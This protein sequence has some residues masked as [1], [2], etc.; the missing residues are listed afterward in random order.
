MK[1]IY[2]IRL[3]GSIQ[4]E[5]EGVPI[6]DFESRKTLALLGYLA[7]Q[8]QPTSRSHLAGLLWGDKTEATGRRNLSRELSQLSSHL[9][10]CFQSD[11][12]TIQFQPVDCWVDTL[13]FQELVKPEVGPRLETEPV[14]ATSAGQ[15][16]LSMADPPDTPAV[17]NTQISNLAEAVA[18]YQGDFM[19][20]FNLDDCPDFE[21]WLVREQE[22]W[23]RQV[24]GI[25]DCLTVY[26]GLRHQYNEAQSYVKR[27]LELEPWQ[28]E[29]HRY[30]MI[31]LARMG[32]RG[33]ALVQYESCRRV[34]AEELDVEPE[35]ETTTLYEQIRTGK[36]EGERAAAISTLL[37]DAR[38][39]LRDLPPCPYRGLFPFR[40]ENAPYFFGRE[41]FT[42]RLVE[43]VHR[44]PL[45]VVIGP[46]G[47]GKTSIVFAG[48]LPHL[49]QER[50]WLIATCRPGSC[51][52]YD[53]ASGLIPLLEPGLK[54]TDRLVETGKLAHALD[55]G[56]LSLAA[57]AARILEKNLEAGRLLLLVDPFEDL[58]SLCPEAG[59]RRRVID[60]LL[61]ISASPVLP[62][63]TPVP[64]QL[65]LTLRTDFL[66]QVLA[67]RP[68]VD[69][70]VPGSDVKLGPMTRQELA[71]AI[72]K[73]AQKQ[74]VAFEA[75]LVE[76][77]LDSVGDGSG[78]LP[79]LEFTLAALWERQVTG[80]LTHAVYEAIGQVAG[81]LAYYA[82][83]VYAGLSQTEQTE[84]RRIFMQLVRPG[85]QTAD[86]RR[87]ASRTEL[88][89]EHWALAR[90]LADARL[91][92]TDQDPTGQET[93]EIVHEALIM[94][95]DRLQMWLN[96]DRVFRVW[97]ERLR[98]ALGQWE[99]SNHDEGALLRGVLLAEAEERVE[100]HHAEINPPE[101]EF[102][103]ASLAW[104]D[105]RVLEKEAQLE[106]E[107]AQL[108]ALAQEQQRR[109]EAEH[110]RA[111]AQVMATRR[112]RWLAA[113][114]V[115]F[116]LA[117]GAGLL[118]MLQ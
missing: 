113:G 64:A 91:V 98:A 92:M 23:R 69:A 71:Q 5:K 49:R 70:L 12:H 38:A 18:L 10:N 77:I 97:H 33:D 105:Q 107:L 7:R 25:L 13:A 61:E 55:E 116:L 62:S 80:Q 100:T 40:E 78:S 41:A 35:A 28:E 85:Q 31:L 50:G 29:A 15:S 48:L 81:S 51:P 79:L 54:E 114:L 93:V 90:R 36:W 95:W 56:E 43:A 11:Y 44:Q 89:E 14:G 53:L 87:R 30:M 104:R 117:V 39:S 63:G 83:D 108:Q 106:R 73:P 17:S 112:L 32:K 20:G 111:E 58:Y 26:H 45:T 118:A 3:L 6:R 74:G 21:T 8:E 75:G 47:S 9:P 84:T 59:L 102:L 42:T 34:L 101:H 72:E 19:T 96:E 67:Y 115:M 4:I 57:V 1:I 88:G 109:T 82:E 24:T 60:M 52:F 99:A 65:V 110:Q 46:S 86:V 2:R 94:G 37:A 66:G 103:Q 76:R 68:F 22:T 27:W 16:P